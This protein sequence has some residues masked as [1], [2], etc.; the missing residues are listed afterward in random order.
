MRRVPD[1]Q[2]LLDAERLHGG[3]LFGYPGPTGD[4]LGELGLVP[5]HQLDHAPAGELLPCR[6]LV[7]EAYGLLQVNV[8]ER[9]EELGIVAYVGLLGHR[10]GEVL[11]L[12]RER[13][14]HVRVDPEDEEREG[15][16]PLMRR[17]AVAPALPVLG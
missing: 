11:E 8:V 12:L 9:L 16:A 14:R 6:H 13:A 3:P 7:K 4:E 17:D 2:V 10:E 5:V 15:L 1:A